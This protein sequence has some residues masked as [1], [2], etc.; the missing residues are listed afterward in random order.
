MVKVVIVMVPPYG[1]SRNM[2]SPLILYTSEIS[3]G[4][5][6]SMYFNVTVPD[7][8]LKVELAL[9][10]KVMRYICPT[11]DWQIARFPLIDNLIVLKN[12]WSKDGRS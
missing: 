8:S 10:L 11:T 6:E 2:D 5:F 12:D 7:L 9:A 3:L 1:Q 4:V